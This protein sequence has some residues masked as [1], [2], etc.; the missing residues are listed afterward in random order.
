MPQVEGVTRMSAIQVVLGA[1]NE[2]LPTL[3]EF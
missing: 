2:A 3:P 1:L